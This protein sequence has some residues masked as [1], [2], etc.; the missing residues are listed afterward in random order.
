MFSVSI[1]PDC[2]PV[3]PM[4]KFTPRRFSGQHVLVLA[5]CLLFGVFCSLLS[6]AA[7]ADETVAAL[8]ARIETTLSG[9][10]RPRSILVVASE[11]AGRCLTVAGDVGEPVPPDG[12]FCLLDA[13]FT[14]LQLAANETARQQLV[15]QIRHDEAELRRHERLLSA[16]AMSQAQIEQ[17]SLQHDLSRLKLSQLET[18]AQS[19]RET[20]TRHQVPAPA[21]WL[22]L[23]RLVEPGGWVSPGQTLTRVGD[24]SA[25]V[26]PL[27][28]TDA[29]M[30]ALSALESF[31]LALPEL[32][33]QGTGRLERISPDFDPASRKTRVEVRLAASTLAALPQRRGGLRVQLRVQLADP[34]GAVLVPAGAVS[35]RHEEHWLTRANPEKSPVRV[36][37]LGAAAAPP[38]TGGEWLRVVSAEVRPGDTFLLSRPGSAAVPA[39]P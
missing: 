17:L 27:T 3:I 22:I 10:T 37:L 15:R 16:Q 33:Q 25:L 24:F 28:V 21:G 4:Q 12:I 6:P 8:P 19:L 20:K 7:A 11:V 14:D 1:T 32:N 35:E 39:T 9:F 23:E 31:P 30:A 2:R 34:S 26:I 36:L 29:E 5:F 18:E 38:D 13:T